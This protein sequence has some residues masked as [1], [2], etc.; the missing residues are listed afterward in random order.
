MAK[1]DEKGFIEDFKNI[2]GEKYKYIGY[3]HGLVHFFCDKHNLD[4]YATPSKIR[5][6]KG[7]PQCVK[8]RLSKTMRMTTEEFIEKAKKVHGDKYD[9]SKVNYVDTKTKVIIVCK[10]HG[11]FEQTP[12]SHLSGKG[13]PICRNEHTGN[14]SRKSLEEF[15]K[16]AKKIHG[17]KYD[18][19][20]VNYVNCSTKVKLICPIHGEF[21]ITPN[22]HLSGRGCRKCGVEKRTKCQTFTTEDFI[23]KARKIHGDKYDYSKSIYTGYDNKLTII[24]PTHGEFEQT[25]DSHFQGSGCRMCAC[26]LSKNEDEIFS[27]I[28]NIVGDG[29]VIKSERTILPNHMEI[30]MYIPLFHLGIEYNGCRWHTEQFGKDKYYHLNKTLECEKHGIRLIHIFEDEYNSKKNIILNKIKHMLNA[31]TDLPKIGGR[32]TSI[33]EISYKDANEFLE[34]N[35]IQGGQRA[36]VYLGA[37]YNDEIIGVMTFVKIDNNGNWELNRFATNIKYICPGVGSK[38]FEYFK[39]KYIPKYIKSFLDRRWVTNK[40]HNI[41]TI[42]GFTVEKELQPDYKYV[43]NGTSNR[44]H[45][46]NFRKNILIKKYN[47]DK[48]LTE[49]QM[50]KKLNAYKIWDCGLIKYI[51]KNE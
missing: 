42:L 1:F 31:L 30:D 37:K 38:L 43:F 49:S 9:Y 10:K 32:K 22:K 34:K 14:I 35:H 23:A 4:C 7:C 48:T 46:F 45:K 47:L 2:H 40:S 51:W 11:E 25:P 41:Y 39:K 21:E 20:L 29:N 5:N 19:S 17:D 15:I 12:N 27:F 36:T 6:G 26:R 24:C 18:Y 33:S 13:C 3:E 16:E 28:K 8:E 50:A 44:I